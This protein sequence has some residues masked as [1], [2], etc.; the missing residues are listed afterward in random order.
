VAT[1]DD[2][3]DVTAR[4]IPSQRHAGSVSERV[5]ENGSIDVARRLQPRLP[6]GAG[7]KGTGNLEALQSKAVRKLKGNDRLVLGQEDNRPVLAC[8][9][10]TRDP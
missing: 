1:V 10:A 2:E 3:R 5:V 7:V 4:K 9:R 6:T 8:R